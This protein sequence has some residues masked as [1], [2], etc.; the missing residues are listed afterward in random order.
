M[1][2]TSKPE[3]VDTP[4]GLAFAITAYVLWG[5][6]PLYLKLLTH[7]PATEVLAHRVIWSVPVAGAVL[8]AMGRTRDLKTV[9]MDRRSCCWPWSRQR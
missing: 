4:Q 7:M 1:A 5:F 6:L 9:L 3:N 2:V 8:I